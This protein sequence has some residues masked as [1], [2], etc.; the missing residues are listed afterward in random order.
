MY[1][2]HGLDFLKEKKMGLLGLA[3]LFDLVVTSFKKQ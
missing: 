3:L 1:E 2:S